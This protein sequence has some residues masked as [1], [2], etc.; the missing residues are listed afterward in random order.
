MYVESQPPPE[1]MDPLLLPFLQADDETEAQRLLAQLIAKHVQPVVREIARS[2]LHVARAAS[3]DGSSGHEAEDLQGEV[4]LQL[5]DR[6]RH[7][8]ECPNQAA[9]TNFRGYVA[10]IAYNSW[11]QSLRRKYPE[12][13][14]LKNRLRYLVNHDGRF[15]LWEGANDTL[16]CGLADWKGPNRPAFASR[17][18]ASES[19]FEQC[20]YDTPNLRQLPPR[21][22]LDVLFSLSGRPIELEELV[23]LVARIWGIK[24][25]HRLESTAE[26]DV[27]VWTRLPDP[28]ENVAAKVERRMYLAALWKEIL[29][30]RP[31]QRAALLL[32]LHDTSGQDMLPLFMLVDVARLSE[33]AVSLDMTMQ[34]FAELWDTLPLDDATIAKRMGITRQQVIN[35]RKSAR[36]RLARRMSKF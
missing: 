11:T 27:E 33:I 30:L 19:E 23:G 15:A 9:I 29:E 12:R 4:V 22:L 18:A 3:A 2:K 6:L 36:E 35:L 26:D 1:N 10:A 13:Q 34:E 31:M 16:L 24:D 7:L 32:N 8:R 20:L 21:A 14:R 28:R 25:L 17:Q 5:L